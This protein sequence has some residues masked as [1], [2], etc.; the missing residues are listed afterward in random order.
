MCKTHTVWCA[1]WICKC[2]AVD[3]AAGNTWSKEIIS[4]F[5]AGPLSF[6]PNEKSLNQS[7]NELVFTFQ[8]GQQCWSAT[9]SPSLSRLRSSISG[10]TWTKIEFWAWRKYFS[11][12]FLRLQTLALHPTQ[13]IASS[14]W[15][16]SPQ[17]KK[18][19]GQ[20]HTQLPTLL[21]KF[22]LDK[23]KKFFVFNK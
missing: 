3:C 8:P 16:C 2:W 15:K 10:W 4:F 20:T 17:V 6:F 21:Y 23:T 14:L 18:Y 11:I 22:F 19:L 13:K 12:N 9:S 5:G 7:V 1:I